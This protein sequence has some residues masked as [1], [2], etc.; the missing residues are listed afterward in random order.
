VAELVSRL[1]K[2]EGFQDKSAYGGKVDSV[3]Q[4]YFTKTL[5]RAIKL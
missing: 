1:K 3:L 5:A 2:T 4:D